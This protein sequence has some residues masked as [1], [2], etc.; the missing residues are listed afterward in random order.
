MPLTR[1][2]AKRGTKTEGG[3]GGGQAERIGGEE[4]E[5]RSVEWGSG[6]GAS[7]QRGASGGGVNKH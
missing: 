6:R 7:W 3:G 5:D 2:E 1:G 4:I